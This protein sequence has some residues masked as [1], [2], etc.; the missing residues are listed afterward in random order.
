MAADVRLVH[1]VYILP[2]AFPSF[3]LLLFT[4]ARTYLYFACGYG[5]SVPFILYIFRMHKKSDGQALLPEVQTLYDRLASAMQ[6]YRAQWLADASDRHTVYF[7]TVHDRLPHARRRLKD[8]DGRIDDLMSLNLGDE[9]TADIRRLEKLRQP[10]RVIAGSVAASFPRVAD[11]LR[12]VAP[13]LA[14]DYDALLQQAARRLHGAGVQPGGLQVAASGSG[15]VVLTSPDGSAWRADISWPPA[16]SVQRSPQV[17]LK[18]QAVPASELLSQSAGAAL[19]S[20]SA[21][22]SLAVAVRSL[23]S[24]PLD[25]WLQLH[26]GYYARLHDKLP[27][28][29]QRSEELSR[30]IQLLS[31][32]PHTGDSAARCRSLTGVLHTFQALSD[33]A[34]ARFDTLD[35]YLDHVRMTWDATLAQAATLFADRCRSRH[36]DTASLRL[37]DMRALPRGFSFTVA[38]GSGFCS[39]VT[40]SF[41]G[42]DGVAVPSL[43]FTF[44]GVQRGAAVGVA[45]EPVQAAPAAQAVTAGPLPKGLITRPRIVEYNGQLFVSCHIAGQRQRPVPIIPAHWQKY[46]SLPGTDMVSLAAAHYPKQIARALAAGTAQTDDVTRGTSH[47]L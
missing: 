11:Y 9:V 41:I 36:L 43:R 7:M 22:D 16:R 1:A 47:K 19:S 45:A 5:F 31:R 15:S 46:R 35:A 24:A 6:P 2:P 10:F 30:E 39:S 18:V 20:V 25:S 26:A 12:H 27:F 8:I 40:A 42:A 4:H 17:R 38:D 32:M 34:A 21:T 23:G 37:S 3:S 33:S 13:K 28:A 29:W 14:S 44:G